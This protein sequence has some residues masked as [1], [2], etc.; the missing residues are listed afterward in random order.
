MPRKAHILTPPLVV[1]V[2]TRE[3]DPLDFGP[4]GVEAERATLHTGDYSCRV[5]DLSYANEIAIERKEFGD[6]LGSLCHERGAPPRDIREWR[7]RRERFR[8]E[9][10][11]LGAMRFGAV[12]VEDAEISAVLTRPMR[13]Q[14]NRWSALASIFSWC[15]AFGVHPIFSPTRQFAA[16]LVSYLLHRYVH[17]HGRPADS[18]SLTQSDS[19]SQGAKDATR[20]PAVAVDPAVSEEVIW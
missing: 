10:A 7:T 20:Q 12:L 6:F 13:S 3:T 19:Q 15:V 4:L 5:G 16:Q 9:C 8:D 18:R 11:R 14:F 17:Y 1:L 2:D